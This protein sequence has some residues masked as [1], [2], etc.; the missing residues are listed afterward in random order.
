MTSPGPLCEPGGLGC[1]RDPAPFDALPKTLMARPIIPSC[2]AMIAGL[3]GSKP[4]D[5]L[6]DGA[7]SL[8]GL[9]WGRQSRAR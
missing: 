8:H 1:L 5:R 6:E 9:R 4:A 7:R 2:A 3:T